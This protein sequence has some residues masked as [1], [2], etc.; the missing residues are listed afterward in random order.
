M[1]RSTVGIQTI[2]QT[3][4]TSSTR[5]NKQLLMLD[6]EQSYTQ[7]LGAFLLNECLDELVLTQRVRNTPPEMWLKTTFSKT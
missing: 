5:P 7:L 6:T 2:T 3:S 1:P 4:M